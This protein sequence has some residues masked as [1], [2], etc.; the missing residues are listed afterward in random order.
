MSL[1]LEETKLENCVYCGACFKYCIIHAYDELDG[2]KLKSLV[3][4][5]TRIAKKG[6]RG[7]DK[8]K[9]VKELLDMCTL[10]GYCD[11]VCPAMVKPFMRNEIAK[12]RIAG[13]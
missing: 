3:V 6:Y 11:K 4:G 13:E 1:E 2:M 5:V 10:Q 7:G 9:K 12:K 8:D